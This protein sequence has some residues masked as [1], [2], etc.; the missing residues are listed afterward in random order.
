MSNNIPS[1]SVKDLK[2]KRELH[3]I[4]KRNSRRSKLMNT[5]S[6]VYEWIAII[7][8]FILTIFVPAH[9][10]YIGLY[11]TDP[12]D[13]YGIAFALLF[14][15]AFFSLIAA[16][17]ASNRYVKTKYIDRAFLVN[18]SSINYNTDILF[19]IRCDAIYNYLRS[20]GIRDNNLIESIIKYYTEQSDNHRKTRWL[21][22]TIFSAFLF[23]LWN[24]F[25]TKFWDWSDI[26]NIVV[27]FLL[28]LLVATN[29]W[30]FRRSLETLVFAKANNYIELANILRTIKSYL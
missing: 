22:F 6:I 12:L 10:I 28:V 15:T 20:E 18:T 25:V 19:T 27:L 5:R 26:G 11:N 30:I 8:L 13:Y 3:E 24:N 7:S 1:V 9:T 29:V 17:L 2:L 21:P 16:G 14:L 23:P 4:I